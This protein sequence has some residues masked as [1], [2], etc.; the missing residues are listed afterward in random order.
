MEQ[1]VVL[2][3]ALVQQFEKAMVK[4]RA[5]LFSAP[6]GFGKTTTARQLLAGREV[7]VRSVGDPHYALPGA[8]EDWQILLVD[9]LQL[10]TGPG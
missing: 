7:C 3:P 6:C 1:Y 5:V 4:G 9:D 8:Q 10:L 2:K